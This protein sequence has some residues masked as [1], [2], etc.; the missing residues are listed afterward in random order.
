MGTIIMNQKHKTLSQSASNLSLK[1][2]DAI[3]QRFQLTFELREGMTS[4]AKFV[5]CVHFPSYV[6]NRPASNIF[7]SLQISNNLIILMTPRQQATLKK[8]WLAIHNGV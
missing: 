7:L 2:T 3:L 8:E 5:L 1:R 6:C 4:D